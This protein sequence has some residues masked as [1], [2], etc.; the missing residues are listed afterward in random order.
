VKQAVAVVGALEVAIDLCAEE[1][2]RER[3]LR[4]TRDARRSPALHGG[5]RRTR[6][7][8]I[9]RTCSAHDAGVALNE[10]RSAHRPA[11]W[12][13]RADRLRKG[14]LR[15][16]AGPRPDSVTLIRSMAATYHRIASRRASVTQ[17]RRYHRPGVDDS[18]RRGDGDGVRVSERFGNALLSLHLD[19]L[20]GLDTR[21]RS[22][23]FS[24]DPGTACAVHGNR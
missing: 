4:V 1:P 6:I 19:N 23:R 10:R 22:R 11:R 13:G 5:H 18:G 9:V 21:D 15:A 3:V 2:I 24:P 14:T 12:R 20:A 17:W 16:G 7:G 8:T